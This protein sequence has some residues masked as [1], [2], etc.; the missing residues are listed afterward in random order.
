SSLTED[1]DEDFRMKDEMEAACVCI[2]EA[3]DAIQAF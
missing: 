3:L 1:C 2:K